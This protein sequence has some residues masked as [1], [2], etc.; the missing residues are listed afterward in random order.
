ML[1]QQ[2]P[3]IIEGALG[4]LASKL[5]AKA[6]GIKVEEWTSSTLGKDDNKGNNTNNKYQ[7]TNTVD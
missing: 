1:E 3:N 2:S 7:I 5:E 4:K 6:R